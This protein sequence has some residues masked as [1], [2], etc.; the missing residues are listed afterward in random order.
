MRLLI[1]VHGCIFVTGLI[2]I[3]IFFIVLSIMSFEYLVKGIPFLTG[4]SPLLFMVYGLYGAVATI[5]E[6]ENFYPVTWTNW[7]Y[8]GG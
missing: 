5:F 8:I 6:M 1:Y 7:E 2:A 4:T 3:V